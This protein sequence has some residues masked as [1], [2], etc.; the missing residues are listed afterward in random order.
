MGKRESSGGP[1]RVARDDRHVAALGID[2][3]VGAGASC[4]VDG[5][6]RRRADVMRANPEN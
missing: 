4:C 1:H 3:A 5:E 6:R 2:S